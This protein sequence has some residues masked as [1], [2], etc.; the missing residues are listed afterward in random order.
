MRSMAIWSGAAA[1][2][3]PQ[4]F[5]GP[6]AFGETLRVHWHRLDFTGDVRLD[7]R[8][9]RPPADAGEVGMLLKSDGERLRNALVLRLRRVASTG[10]PGTAPGR[11][12]AQA[13]R[14]GEAVRSTEV[15]WSAG[16][17][18]LSA[19]RLKGTLRLFLGN[20]PLMAIS[21]EARAGTRLAWYARSASVDA[22]D[23]ELYSDTMINEFFEAAPT[24][25]REG[26]GVWHMG[27]KWECDPRWTFFTGRS[28]VVRH[29]ELQDT[30]LVRQRLVAL[31]SKRV[32][33]GDFTI[34][35]FVGQ[36][37]DNSRGRDYSYTRDLNLSFCA[38]GSDLT[39]G[40]AFVFG[41]FGNTGSALIRKGRIW[42]RT[43]SLVIDRG[44]LHRRWYHIR[45]ARRG[46]EV[47]IHIDGALRFRKQDPEP[48]GDGHFALWTY[49]N[50]IIIGRVR[51]TADDIGPRD[52]VDAPAR[53]TTQSLYR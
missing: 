45:A 47:T 13:W 22:Q 53:P 20:R 48:L 6:E 11:L 17:R 32:L 14:D 9:R 1:D 5:S 29:P 3:L 16:P 44:G 43:E 25:W 40:Y 38:N 42:E 19:R 7:M 21:D 39:S 52:S 27:S 28:P 41:G 10:A 8:L 37:M 34:E 12:V 23:V 49:D 50:G 51:I 24:D 15:N 26:G 2:W 36:M 4:R 30:P 46:A 33:K 35:Y 18:V 31:W